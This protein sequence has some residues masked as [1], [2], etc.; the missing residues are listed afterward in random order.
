MEEMVATWKELPLREICDVVQYGYTASAKDE[1]IGP[2]FLRITD[3]VPQLI[4]WS[5]VPHCQIDEKKKVKYK[6]EEGDIVVART[7]ATTGYAKWIRNPP[8]SVFASYLVRLK[9]KEG[10]NSRYVGLVVE[11]DLYKKF[12]MTNVGGAAQPNANAQILISYPIKLPPRDIQDRIVEIISAYD[13]L[14]ENNTRRIKILEEMAQAIYREWFVK[15]RFPGHEKV[16]MIDSSL[17]PI[18]E[19]WEVK[20]LCDV[21]ELKYGKGLK[22]SDRREG[23]VPVFG[24][25]GIVGYHDARLVEGPGVIV[26]RKGNVGSVFWSDTAFVPIDT[27]FYV[28]TELPLLYVYFSLQ[29]Q[30]FINGD[31]AVPGLSRSQAYL[32]PYIVPPG[33]ALKKFELVVTPMFSALRLLNQKNANLRATCDLLLPKLI[34]G[35]LDISTTGQGII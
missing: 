16:K 29:H 35:E 10:I 6:L 28:V 34:S 7:G 27:V 22:K 17:G 14:I 33:Y 1:D 23:K 12:I 15:F 26:G 5:A 21:V 18:P 3:I 11:S 9:I 2:R 13:D 20:R 24:S 32:L 4:D 25:S 19:G 8:D 31:A 30:P